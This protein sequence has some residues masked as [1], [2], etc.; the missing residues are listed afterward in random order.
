I[1]TTGSNMVGK[2]GFDITNNPGTG[3]NMNPETGVSPTAVAGQ[4]LNNLGLG[5]TS[6]TLGYGGFVLSASSRSVDLTLRALRDK[7]RLQILS[8][9]Q[10]TAMD[11]QQ[12]FILVGQRV[13]RISG[14]NMTSTGVIQRNTTDTPIGLILLVTPR[15]TKDGKVVM[16]IGAEKSGL[17]SDGV[18]IE[19][20]KIQSIDTIQMMTA[21]SARDGETV[22][23]GGLLTSQKEKVGRGVP[24]LS[25]I[26]VLGWLFRYDREVEQRKELLIVMTPHILRN[27]EDFERVKRIEASKMNWDLEKAMEING[28]MGLYDARTGSGFTTKRTRSI[29]TDF[30]TPDPMDELQRV[31]PYSPEND[32]PP[33]S[34]NSDDSAP[35]AP[36]GRYINS[37][38]AN[39]FDLGPI[40]DDF[41]ATKSSSKTRVATNLR[42]SSSDSAKKKT[43]S[44]PATTKTASASATTKVAAASASKTKE[45]KTYG[46]ED[47][48]IQYAN[49]TGAPEEL[50]ESTTKLENVQSRAIAWTPKEDAPSKR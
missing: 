1:T 34:L 13:P 24:Y 37:G 5:T 16:E 4:V 17:G 30:C 15:V 11:N 39:E 23:L 28:N 35:A 43:A 29:T 38:D 8:R 21:I 46:D 44:A 14:S 7:N 42:Q 27:S 32:Y 20:S 31:K 6:S 26:P 12:A 36:R 48:F 18:E 41:S 10:V 25:D 50:A 9:P 2:P 33:P 19:G 22:M 49:P 47:A 3:Q 45:R 40:D